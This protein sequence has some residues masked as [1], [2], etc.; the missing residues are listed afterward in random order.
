MQ[1]E[2]EQAA[3]KLIYALADRAKD[4]EAKNALNAA[5][6]VNQDDMKDFEDRRTTETVKAL[7][8]SLQGLQ[9]LCP[10]DDKI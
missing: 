5:L 8:I 6:A 4:W 3:N 10:I 1:N 2:M 7:R 9:H